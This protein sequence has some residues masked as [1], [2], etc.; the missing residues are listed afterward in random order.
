MMAPVMTRMPMSQNV[1][2]GGPGQPSQVQQQINM[3]GQVGSGPFFQVVLTI[4]NP[5]I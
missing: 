3:P 4:S 1:A 2:Q 5:Q